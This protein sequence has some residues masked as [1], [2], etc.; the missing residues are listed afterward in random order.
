MAKTANAD[1][2]VRNPD[3]SR[4]RAIQTQ[5]IG[6]FGRVGIQSFRKLQTGTG[7]GSIT[8]NG[9]VQHAEAIFRIQRLISHSDRGIFLDLQAR[10]EGFQGGTVTL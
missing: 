6:I 7:T 2:L 10:F 1:F 9:I 4:L 5:I 8:V 3:I